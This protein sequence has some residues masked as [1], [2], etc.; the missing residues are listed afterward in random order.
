MQ[1]TNPR[2]SPRLID[3]I[4]GQHMEHFTAIATFV[5]VVDAGSFTAAADTLD[6]ARS[7]VSRRI[8]ALEARLETRLLHRTTRRLALTDAGKLFYERAERAMSQ[9]RDA[10]REISQLRDEPSGRLVISVPMSFGLTHIFPALPALKLRYPKLELDVRLEDRQVDLLREGVDLAIR[11]ADLDTSSLVAR[12]LATVAHCV[13]ASPAYLA[14]RTAPLLP[15]D[16]QAHECLIYTLSK[17]PGTWRLRCAEAP[18][19]N[20]VA[21]RGS[22]HAN[23]SLALREL[24]LAGMGVALLPDFVVAR[25]LAEGRLARL[26]G[27]WHATEL[28]L[29]VVY[30]TRRHVSLAV[31][32]FIEFIATRVG[33]HSSQFAV[34]PARRGKSVS[35]SDRPA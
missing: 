17:T 24:A 19:W 5:A 13:V 3:F 29:Y 1:G 33:A 14:R 12:K 34:E 2:S 30:P 6:V 26:L 20:A 10:E 18:E 16:L 28:G 15:G 25:D 22:M 7:V 9:M 23:N 4:L 32:A 27:D 21:V 8:G 11:I 31:K 35:P